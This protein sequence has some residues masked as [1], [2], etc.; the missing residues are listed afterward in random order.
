MYRLEIEYQYQ[1]EKMWNMNKIIVKPNSEKDIKNLIEL[2]IDGVILPLKNLSVG[3]SFFMSLEDILNLKINKEKIVLI[4][5]IMHNKD[6]ELLRDTLIKLN[7]SDVKKIIFYDLSVYT[8]SK[9][10]NINNIEL[11]IG[12]DHLN[13]SIKS[14]NFYNELGINYSYITSDITIDEIK[15]IK[16]NTKMKLF[17]TVYGR[18]PLFCSRRYLISNYLEYINKD[19]TDSNYYIKNRED[20]LYINEEDNA[21]LIYSDIINLIN[22]IDELDFIDYLVLDFNNIEEYKET[23]LKFKNK[24]KD[25]KEYYLGFYNTKTIYKVKK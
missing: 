15:E 9:E 12:Q 5:K 13:R 25:G 21:T 22:K 7:N 6:L 24:I 3:S 2:D 11:V 10:L 20:E 4:N 18:I 16:D 8:L 17:Y 23:I 19:K 1:L 14:N